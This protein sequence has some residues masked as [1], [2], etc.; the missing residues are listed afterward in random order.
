MCEAII[1]LGEIAGFVEM[2]I[3]SENVKNVM[4]ILLIFVTCVNW[5]CYDVSFF[6]KNV[7]L[8]NSIY[9][10]SKLFSIREYSNN[11]Q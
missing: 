6:V 9:F 1:I 8:S 5:E 10:Y 2:I 4:K 3:S 11:I 7:W